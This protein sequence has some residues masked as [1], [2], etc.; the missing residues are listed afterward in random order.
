MT[1]RPRSVTQ[2]DMPAQADPGPLGHVFEPSAPPQL[3]REQAFETV[4][5][6]IIAGRLPP[7]ARLIEREMCAALGV[8]RT[9]VREVIRRLEAERLVHVAARRGPRVASLSAK[10][11]REIYDLRM[12]LEV[13]LVRDFIRNAGDSD[14]AQLGAL[15]PE[16]EAAANAGDVEALVGIMRRFYNALTTGADNAVATDILELLHA[17]ISR[18]RVLSMS[19]PG[20]ISRSVHEIAEIVAAIG[21]RDI[22]QAELATRTYVAAAR[23]AALRQ[24]GAVGLTVA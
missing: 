3:M 23:D 11:A 14:V 6:A 8:S 1:S 12:E 13:L 19:D 5:D 18:L 20:R 21:R 16:I 17:R 4:K 9:I 22:D 10:T 15:V 2:P 7:G 24:I